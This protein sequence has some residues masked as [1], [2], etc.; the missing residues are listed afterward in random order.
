MKDYVDVCEIAWE[1]RQDLPPFYIASQFL[2]PTVC[3]LSQRAYL[4]PVLGAIHV[5][6]QFVLH[7]PLP[8]GKTY[9]VGG[10]VGRQVLV[11][12]T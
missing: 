9:T 3:L 2:F 11:L 4:F 10:W 8:G 5:L 1:G 12:N 6:N 7:K